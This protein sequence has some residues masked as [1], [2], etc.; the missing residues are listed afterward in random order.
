MI[1]Q[2]DAVLF[3]IPMRILLSW[4]YLHNYNGVF[5]SEIKTKP[6]SERGQIVLEGKKLK[7]D[8]HVN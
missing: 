5:K 2:V 4:N 1:C 7:L 3:I 6:L 8:Q